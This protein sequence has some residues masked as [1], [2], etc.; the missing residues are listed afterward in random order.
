MVAFRTAETSWG[1]IGF[2]GFLLRSHR[3]GGI[4]GRGHDVFGICIDAI[5]SLAPQVVG[6]RL[7][8]GN[9]CAAAVIGGDGAIGGT[10][11][12]TVGKRIAAFCGKNGS[13][14]RHIAVRAQQLHG[15]GLACLGGIAVDK[16]IIL[17]CK[18]ME[19]GSA[20][21]QEGEAGEA[22]NV[23]KISGFENDVVRG[24]AHGMLPST[25]RLP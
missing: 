20:V 22:G 6:A 17:V 5:S 2:F 23:D 10:E 13:T 15:N 4:G 18:Q 12:R 25:E 9:G 21:P 7:I 24:C 14:V 19:A 3:D 16:A 1:F 8:K 11:G